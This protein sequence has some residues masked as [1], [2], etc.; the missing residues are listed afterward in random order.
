[1]TLISCLWSG[2]LMAVTCVF[3]IF[4]FGKAIFLLLDAD[5]WKGYLKGAIMLTICLTLTI[6]LSQWVTENEN[7][8]Y[9]IQAEN[10]Q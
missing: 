6:G 4:T 2:F 5:D 1:M 3:F 7:R 10:Q 8:R 9:S